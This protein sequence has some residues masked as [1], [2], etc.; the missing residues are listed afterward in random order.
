ML[1]RSEAAR[2][3]AKEDQQEHAFHGSAGANGLPRCSKGCAD[4]W[5]AAPFAVL[6]PSLS[7]LH[8]EHL[9]M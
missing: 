1:R 8:T 3:E 2:G 6:F 4:C 9:W 7:L 5:N